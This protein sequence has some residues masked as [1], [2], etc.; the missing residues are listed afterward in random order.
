LRLLGSTPQYDW[1]GKG[2]SGNRGTFRAEMLRPIGLY[3]V[4]R[5]RVIVGHHGKGPSRIAPKCAMFRSVWEPV[6]VH[7][8]DSDRPDLQGTS[9]LFGSER[10]LSNGAA[11]QAGLHIVQLQLCCQVV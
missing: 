6:L 3:G 11:D 4:S 1:R 7:R 2:D 10:D 8:C 5:G 9:V